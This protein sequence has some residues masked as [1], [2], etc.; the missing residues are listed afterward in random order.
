LPEKRIIAEL[1]QK[2]IGLTVETR[3]GDELSGI[4]GSVRSLLT[5]KLTYQITPDAGDNG[6]HLYT[7]IFFRQAPPNDYG[8][9]IAY[10]KAQFTVKRGERVLASFETAESKDGGLDSYQ[11]KT[12]AFAKLMDQLKTDNSLAE[13][14]ETAAS[15]R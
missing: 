11:A 3:N 12:R 6:P 14:I 1:Q 9:T 7:T 10:A 15:Y 4:D 5:D 13:K 8:L 2:A